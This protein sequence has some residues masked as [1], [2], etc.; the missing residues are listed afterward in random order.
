MDKLCNE[1][2]SEEPQISVFQVTVEI[3]ILYHFNISIHTIE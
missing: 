1:N 2:I 3:V